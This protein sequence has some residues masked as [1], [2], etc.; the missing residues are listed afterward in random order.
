MEPGVEDPD[1]DCVMC[2]VQ[3]KGWC[4]P[5]FTVRVHGT[6]LALLPRSAID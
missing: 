1:K 6:L 4:K 2:N 5:E 3:K